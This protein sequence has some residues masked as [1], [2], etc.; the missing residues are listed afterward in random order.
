LKSS[1]NEIEEQ[2]LIRLKKDLNIKHFEVKDFTGRHLNHK[3][4]DGGFHLET[5]IVSDDFKDKSLIERHKM[6]YKAVGNLMKHEIHALSMKT[7]T[8]IE[9]KN[10]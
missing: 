2:I 4:N 5:I 8:I 1:P 7:L 3:L 10:S 9:W 6:V